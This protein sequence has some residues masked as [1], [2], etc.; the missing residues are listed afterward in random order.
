M[1]KSEKKKHLNEI[2]QQLELQDRS[3]QLPITTKVVSK[4]QKEKYE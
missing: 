3:N 1:L 2:Q 4:K